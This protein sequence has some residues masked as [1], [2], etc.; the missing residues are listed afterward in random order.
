MEDGVHNFKLII[1]ILEGDEAVEQQFVATANNVSLNCANLGFKFLATDPKRS[2]VWRVT[3][4]TQ[5]YE[6]QK[7]NLKYV[8]PSMTDQSFSRS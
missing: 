4:V 3:L 1:D 8:L 6:T 5:I 7:C 2:L